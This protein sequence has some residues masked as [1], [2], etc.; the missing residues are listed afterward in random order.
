MET[1][2]MQVC[3]F[4]LASGK[5]CQ[6][7]LW[8]SSVIR[9][10]VIA[11]ESEVKSPSV[12]SDSLRPHRL[13]DPWNSAGKNTG[14]GSLSLLQGIFQTQGLNP[15]LPHCRQILS[16]LSHKGGPR[17]VDWV[18]FPFCNG[19]GLLTQES[20]WDLLQWRRILHQLRHQGNQISLKTSY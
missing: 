3:R 13:Y 20:N 9:I 15:G 10:Q 8:D 5:K 4:W 7:T 16:R 6:I 17:I 18:A 12:M 19:S 1:L 14:V 11:F 2:E